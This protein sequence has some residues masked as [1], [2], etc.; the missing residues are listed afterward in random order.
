MFDFFVLSEE[1]ISGIRTPRKENPVHIPFKDNPF[2]KDF[3]VNGSYLSGED[4]FLNNSQ[5][6]SAWNSEGHTADN[7][8]FNE[9]TFGF[10]D[11]FLEIWDNLENISETK[12]IKEVNG[13]HSAYFFESDEEDPVFNTVSGNIILLP[14]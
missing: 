12:T 4:I 3:L 13:N 1:R 6:P 8:S 7:N 14:M 2:D 11:N 9:L 5:Q 10:K